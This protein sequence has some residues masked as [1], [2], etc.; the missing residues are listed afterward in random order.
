[1]D[2]LKIFYIFILI[3]ILIGLLYKNNNLHKTCDFF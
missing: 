2:V 3:V 1:M